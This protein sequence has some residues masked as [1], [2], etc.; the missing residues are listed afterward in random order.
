MTGVVL[1][2]AE[3]YGP[4]IFSSIFVLLGYGTLGFLDDLAKIKK[5]YHIGI[6]PKAKLLIQI[7]ISLIVLWVLQN[8]ANYNK[9]SIWIPIANLFINLGYLYPIFACF[10]IIGSSNAVNLTDGIDG[11]A[12]LL[13]TISFSAIFLICFII[14]AKLGFG[15]NLLHV[16][17]FSSSQLSQIAILCCAVIGSS[18]GFLWFNTYPAS[19]FMGD[20]GSLSLGGLFGTLGIMLHIEILIAVIGIIFVIETLSVIMQVCYFKYSGGKRIFLM[21]PIHHHFEKLGLHE[22]EIVTKFAIITFISSTYAV[23]SFGFG[24][25]LD[26]Y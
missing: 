13:I 17:S 21:T 25:I 9:F 4:Y 6:K 2:F 10:V 22:S 1:I 11:L 7:L 14:G 23:V 26:V 20:T 15:S 16:F 12:S 3:N 5:N 8:E 24:L 18:I 19:I